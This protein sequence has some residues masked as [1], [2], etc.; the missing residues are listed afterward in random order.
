MTIQDPTE[1]KPL[2]QMSAAQASWNTSQVRQKTGSSKAASQKGPLQEIEV[3][4]KTHI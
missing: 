3:K 4:R 2:C 1:K